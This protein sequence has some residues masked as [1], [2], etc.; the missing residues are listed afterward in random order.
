MGF[1][2]F[3]SAFIPFFEV[4]VKPLREIMMQKYT[5]HVGNLWDS[6]ATTAFEELRHCILRDPCLRRFDH[7]K[8]TIL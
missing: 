2:Q 8:F 7:K 4:R 6:T 1:L 5:S 3:Y